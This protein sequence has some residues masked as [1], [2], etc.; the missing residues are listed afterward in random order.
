[1]NQEKREHEMETIKEREPSV[2][3]QTE[4]MNLENKPSKKIADE[5]VFPLD[6]DKADEFRS[7][8]RKIQTGFVDNPR[9]SV[10]KA[11]ELVENVMNSITEA[12]GKERAYLEDQWNQGA[13][14]STED[15]RLAIK[16]YRSFFNRLLTLEISEN[17]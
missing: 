8:W 11:D 17:R 4:E 3:K 16:R 1:M 14:A 2:E 5:F 9:N 13:N 10:E 12:F 15:L 6:E 7:H